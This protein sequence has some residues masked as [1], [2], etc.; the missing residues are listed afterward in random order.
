MPIQ[1][2]EDLLDG[3]RLL[4][5]PFYIRWE[6][7]EMSRE[8]LI[9]YARQYYFVEKSL[10]ELAEGPEWQDEKTHPEL[11]LRF[12]DALGLTRDEVRSA[13]VALATQDLVALHEDCAKSDA[14][15]AGAMFAYEVQAAGIAKVKRESLKSK[16]DVTEGLGFFEAHERVEDHH[17]AVGRA[18]VLDGGIESLD[19]MQ[20]ALDAHWAFLDQALAVDLAACA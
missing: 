2:P 15:R 8:G 6:A 9:D 12:A 16:Y 7:G 5:H 17:A 18:A 19:S 10:S 20:Q 13:D 4:E 14:A 3:R 11:W 1:Q